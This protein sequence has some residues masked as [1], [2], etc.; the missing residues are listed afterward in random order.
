[1]FSFR[2]YEDY[3]SMYEWGMI[4]LYFIWIA[5]IYML[6]SNKNLAAAWKWIV[7]VAAFFAV[8]LQC[9]LF[10]GKWDFS[11]LTYFTLMSNVACLLYFP[12]AALYQHRTG[13]SWQPMVKGAIL[14]CISVTGLVYHFMLHGRFAMQGTILI[15]NSLLHYVVPI[16]TVID[17]LVFDELG[18]WTVFLTGMIMELCFFLLGLFWVWL[19]R[20]LAKRNEEKQA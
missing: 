17:W 16:C 3:T 9:G 5:A 4:G 11:C 19:D 2:Y 13:R 7:A 14:M 15:S 10:R 8:A 20:R 12:V 18:F 6:I 1:M